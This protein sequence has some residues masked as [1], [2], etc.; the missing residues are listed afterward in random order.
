[1]T[2]R[3]WYRVTQEASRLIIR[4]PIHITTWHWISSRNIKVRCPGDGCCLCGIYEQITFLVFVVSPPEVNQAKLLELPMR[5]DIAHLLIHESDPIGIAIFAWRG[6][7]GQNGSIEA[8]FGHPA[9]AWTREGNPEPRRQEAKEVQ[10]K[11]Y[12]AAL[13]RRQYEFVAKQFENTPE[14]THSTPTT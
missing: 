1:M 6:E 13:G 12:I 7:E 3:G 2:I 8:S 5:S 11:N 9:K 4:S 10:A 14:L